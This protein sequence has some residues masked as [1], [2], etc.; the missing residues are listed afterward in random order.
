V[1]RG[2]NLFCLE[3]TDESEAV[4]YPPTDIE[5]KN[6]VPLDNIFHYPDPFQSIGDQSKAY[7]TSLLNAQFAIWIGFGQIGA[8]RLA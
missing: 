6:L 1:G 4:I 7:T 3:F 8:S 2:T 5:Q